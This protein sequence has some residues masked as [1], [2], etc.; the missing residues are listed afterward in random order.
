MTGSLQ[1]YEVGREE[2]G[3]SQRPFWLCGEP[4]LTAEVG[5][6]EVGSIV[7][8]LARTTE[9]EQMRQRRGSISDGDK[10]C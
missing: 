6:R 3:V 8:A 10:T 2:D 1:R 5:Q 4:H 9:M 7:E